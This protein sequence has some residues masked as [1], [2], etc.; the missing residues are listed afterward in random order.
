[1]P[2]LFDILLRSESNRS[3][4]RCDRTQNKEQK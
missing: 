4:E 2:L 3:L 1:M